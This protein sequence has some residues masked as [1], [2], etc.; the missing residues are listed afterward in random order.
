MTSTGVVLG[1]RAFYTGVGVSSGHWSQRSTRCDGPIGRSPLCA[2]CCAG[3]QAATGH[4]GVC[5]TVRC[6][7]PPR[8]A[9][10]DALVRAAWRSSSTHPALASAYRA[11]CRRVCHR[12]LWP[13]GAV[14]SA[15]ALAMRLW[16]V[17]GH[18]AM[19]YATIW[20]GLGVIRTRS[21]GSVL[22]S[23]PDAG[24]GHAGQ[25]RNAATRVRGHDGRPGP[26][27]CE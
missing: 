1:A 5:H 21:R 13:R 25:G 2:P 22:K 19:P 7:L 18:T 16:R 11:A 17:H 27:T 26:L 6:S 4:G 8:C 10:I 14:F 9:A 23:T 15:A 3:A 24:T 20:H 12:C